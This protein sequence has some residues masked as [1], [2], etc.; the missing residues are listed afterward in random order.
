MVSS[1]G[2]FN[3]VSKD[4]FG[5]GKSMNRS[6]VDVMHIDIPSPA[7][8]IESLFNASTAPVAMNDPSFEQPKAD[9]DPK[10]TLMEKLHPDKSYKGPDFNKQD[11]MR[12]VNLVVKDGEK[13]TKRTDFAKQENDKQKETLKQDF[14]A[15]KAEA[16]ECLKEAAISN[17]C[18]PEVAVDTLVSKGDSS[19]AGAAT[20]IFA[21]AATGGMGSLATM[22]KGGAVVVTASKED[23]KLSPEKQEALLEDTL[24][25]LQSR[26]A[27]DQDTRMS[28]SANGGAGSAPG[29][30]PNGHSEA[31]WENFDAD[32]LEEFLATDVKK[33]PEWEDA[34]KIEYDIGE[35]QKNQ[36]FV[37]EHYGEHGDIV[38]KAEVM[39]DSGQ[40]D[41]LRRELDSSKVAVDSASVQLSGAS[42]AGFVT[43]KLPDSAANDAYGAFENVSD[44]GER[45][46]VVKASEIETRYDYPSMDQGVIKSELTGGMMKQMSAAFG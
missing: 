3:E 20:A 39:A 32:D 15:D 6:S 36:R 26:S 25:Q 19:K 29:P 2:S 8:S 13:I 10:E 38:A 16:V 33:L 4:G 41:V 17:Q 11:N 22:G 21:E 42:L 44:I 46:A 40:S 28:A 18:S 5:Y 23:Q 37:A 35:A 12:D 9:Q 31:H 34:C 45:L 1:L 24:K 30:M 7:P 43:I 14:E 27:S